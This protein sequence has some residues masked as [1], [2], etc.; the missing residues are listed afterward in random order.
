MS[1]GN[2]VL[3]LDFGSQYTQLIARRVREAEVYC[4]IHPG[5]AP[6][7]TIQARK[8]NAV[9]LSGGPQSVYDKDSPQCDR[10]VFDLGVPV[11]GICYGQQLLA[12]QLGGKVSPSSEREYGAAQLEV[13]Q[14]LGI[15]SPFPRGEKLA[16][17]MSHG[18]S[19]TELPPG[20]VR[21]GHSDNAPFAAIGNAERKIYGIQF[22]PEVAHTPRG[23]DLLDAFLFKVAG[24]KPD[25]TPSS[26]VESSLKHIRQ[27]V[28][29]NEKVL[30]ALSGGVD[31]AVA[32]VLTHRAIGDQL[33]CVFVD[34]GVLR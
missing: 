29:P 14:S 16:V 19:I 28:G 18:D 9:V 34:N 2:F 4:E 12:H 11:L 3:I 8:P 15:L 10:G 6:L 5:N 22:H 27:M 17:W 13:D 26:F 1:S 21:I 30:C 33:V 31:S 32:A 24:L 7:S 20:F 25:W 23:R